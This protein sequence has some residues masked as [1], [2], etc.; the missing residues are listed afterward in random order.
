MTGEDVAVVIPCYGYGRYLG[1]AVESALAQTVPPTRILVVDDDSPDDTKAV[2]AA[3]AD[4][5]VDYVWQANAGPAA[6]RNRAAA[7]V[8]EPL[9]VFL[10]ADDRL[11][12][13]YIER[14]RAVLDAAPASVGY[15]YTQVRYFGAEE[16]VE[17]HYPPWS[18]DRL[19]R[20]PF[21]HPAALLRRRLALE[22]PFDERR[23]PWIEDWDFFLTLAEHGVEGRL[24]DEPLLWYRR[25]DTASRSDE[26]SEDPRGY[27]VYRAVLRNHRQL[28]GWRR[29]A[30]VEGYYLKRRA[31]DWLSDRRAGR[32]AGHRALA[33]RP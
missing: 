14:T 15:V 31:H 23:T 20:W 29:T 19:L 32:G 3:F 11:D 24:L 2:A 1:E 30:R 21:V 16:G 4:R 5:G 22:H 27:L 17:T 12:P 25:H 6:A 10:D 28:A 9:V 26:I 8:S 18:V 7:M 33:G 13:R